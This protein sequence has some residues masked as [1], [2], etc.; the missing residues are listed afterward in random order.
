[1]RLIL[2]SCQSFN[3]QTKIRGKE[4]K[5]EPII[6]TPTSTHWK[7]EKKAKYK[8]PTLKKRKSIQ[9]NAEAAAG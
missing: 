8:N 6:S 7:D 3:Q 2:R 1:M 9:K 5:K 4:T